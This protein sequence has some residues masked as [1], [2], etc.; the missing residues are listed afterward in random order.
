[1]D[2]RTLH[3][4]TGGEDVS[5]IGGVLSNLYDLLLCKNR[6]SSGFQKR[7]VFESIINVVLSRAVFKITASTVKRVSIFVASFFS[8]GAWSDKRLSHDPVDQYRKGFAILSKIS[9]WISARSQAFHYFTS[10]DHFMGSLDMAFPI[11]I[12]GHSAFANN[13]ARQALDPS[14]ARNLISSFK[15]DNRSPFLIVKSVVYDGQDDCSYCLTVERNNTFYVGSGKALCAS[16]CDDGHNIKESESETIRNETVRWF[17]ES[18]SS[19]LNNMETGAKIVIM[20]RVNE[21]DIAGNI[22]AL[23]L[24]YCHLSISMEFEWD[25]A[26]NKD[27]GEPETTDIGWVDP[28]WR[29]DKEDCEGELAWPERFPEDVVH[30]IKKEV[31]PYGFSSQ[32]QQTPEPRGGGLIKREWWL[33]AEPVMSNDGQKYPPFSYI[34]AS[35]DGAYTEKEQ[36]DPSAM[37]VWGIFEN[38]HGYNR[39]MLIHAWEKRLQFSGPRIDVLPGEHESVYRRRCM[40]HWGL[41]EW[42]ADT[43]KRFKADKLLIEAKATG[44]S[45]AQSLRNSHGREGWSIELIDPKGDKLARGMAI[46]PSFSQEMI[47]APDREWATKTI[48][49]CAIFPYGKNDDLF[50]TVTQAIKHFRDSGLI[51]SDEER[52]AQEMDAVRHRGAPKKA[53]YPGFRARS[54]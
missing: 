15:A 40:P 47:Y 21:D 34:V 45:T 36:N 8:F 22:L 19:R 49:Q 31:G 6:P 4:I 39:A 20:Q 30:R 51:R 27:T 12:S 35:V 17:R 38:E 2:G 41:I 24:P 28:R 46:V 44:I 7:A 1:L 5:G 13:Y 16:N 33:P 54:A 26:T 29:P 14:H 3:T 53:L 11:G 32:Y 50:D 37:T 52:R 18:M 42:V 10:V 48:D 25:A 23:G 9:S 43:C